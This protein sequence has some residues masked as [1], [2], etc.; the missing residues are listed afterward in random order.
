MF[1]P[2]RAAG[3]LH[4]RP[5]GIGPS[6]VDAGPETVPPVLVA[7]CDLSPSL[8]ARPAVDLVARPGRVDEATV[9]ARLRPV[10]VRPERR[11]GLASTGCR[12]AA[13][14]GRRAHQ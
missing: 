14:R 11:V 3:L 1:S 12:A 4:R 5:R 13:V 6:A 7:T 8:T 9:R 2:A 10:Q